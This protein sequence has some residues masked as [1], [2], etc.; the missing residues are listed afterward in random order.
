MHTW[1]AE[2]LAR[3]EN[4]VQFRNMLECVM[5]IGADFHF[6]EEWSAGLC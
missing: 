5:I 6:T 4:D 3:R 2:S 1:D